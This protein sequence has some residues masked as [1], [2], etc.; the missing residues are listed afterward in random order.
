MENQILANLI[1]QFPVAGVLILIIIRLYNDLT[2]AN[3]Q[4]SAYR[5]EMKA[6]ITLVREQNVEMKMR[7]VRLEEHLIGE[8]FP[9]NGLKKERTD[10][11]T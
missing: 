7:I 9:T 2:K 5:E 8:K 11:P 1:V 3:T 6:E 4:A 10:V